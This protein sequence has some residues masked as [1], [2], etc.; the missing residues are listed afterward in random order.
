VISSLQQLSPQ[1]SAYPEGLRHY[2]YSKH[3]PALSAWGDLALLQRKKLALFCSSQCPQSLIEPAQ[4]L[5]KTLQNS[6]IVVISGFHTP[7]EQDCLRLLGQTRQ[8]LIHCPARSLEKMQLSTDQE[9]AIAQN[10]LLLLSPFPASQG[11]ATAALAHR[12]NQLVAAL[13]DQV[14][15]IHASPGSKTEAIAQ[16]CLNWGKPLLTLE[17]AENHHL[18]EL[19]ATFYSGKD[20]Q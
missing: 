16:Q 7:I 8:L 13:A 4:E 17:A 1:D 14:L 20:W 10:R 9:E 18:K 15:M 11:R 2:V 12:R 5:I 19:G 3:L 6:E